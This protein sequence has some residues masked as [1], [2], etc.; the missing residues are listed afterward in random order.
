VTTQQQAVLWFYDRGNGSEG[1]VPEHE[2][3]QMLAT[4]VLSTSDMVSDGRRYWTEASHVVWGDL[5]P[6]HSDGNRSQEQPLRRSSSILEAVDSRTHHS[7]SYRRGR[8]Y[9]IAASIVIMLGSLVIISLQLWSSE[10]AVKAPLYPVRLA[11]TLAL[12]IMLLRGSN[13]A[14]WVAAFMYSVVGFTFLRG[15]VESL[16]EGSVSIFLA[17]FGALYMWCGVTLGLAPSVNIF[18]AKRRTPS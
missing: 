17:V 16:P 4:G 3:R 5:P 9:V 2:L 10:G 14:R 13:W 7:V 8:N 1:P 18:F 6:V 11:L 15:S 12:C